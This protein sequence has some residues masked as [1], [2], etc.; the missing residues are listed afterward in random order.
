MKTIILNPSVAKVLDGLPRDIRN[1]ITEALDAYAIHGT[2]D[3]KAMS[4]T[5]TVRLRVGD[6][7]VI[8]DE[9]AS[10]ILVLAL[11]HRRDVYR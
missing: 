11:G 3:T 8:F 10:T 7:R 2:G 5:S 6:Y 9:T 4:G 1:R